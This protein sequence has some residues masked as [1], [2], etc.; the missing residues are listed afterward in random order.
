MATRGR[1]PK[2]QAKTDSLLA[3]L[4][5]IA[6]AQ[7]NEGTILQRHCVLH[8]GWLAATDNVMTLACKVTDD[9]TA[10]P[11][12][13]RLIA[14]L[15]RC[16]AGVT[17]TQEN[18]DRLRVVSAGLRVSVPCVE[19]SSMALSWADPVGGPLTPAFIDGLRAIGHITSETGQDLATGSILCEGGMLKAVNNR[20]VLVEYWHGEDSP[21]YWVL[22]A[23]TV[24]ALIKIDKK[25]VGLG[26]S[27]N[28]ATFHYEDESWLK[29]QLYNDKWPQTE[30]VWKDSDLT[31]SV[32]VPET[33][34]AAVNTL[35]GL[36]DA[37]FVMMQEG[38]LVTT[39]KLTDASEMDVIGLPAGPTLKIKNLLMVAKLAKTMHIV[40]DS[41][42][43]IYFY[44]DKTRMAISIA[45]GAEQ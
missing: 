15:E 8:S 20:Q 7:S 41:S 18:A 24:D 23:A 5:F 42:R 10:C 29:T 13:K 4:R 35:S 6:L 2:S 32:P 38:K 45:V 40:S 43:V 25:L 21:P 3:A 44:G 27:G 30:N 31:G 34:F 12:T 26:F 36:T 37:G 22:P 17:I 11:Q 16:G 19:L 1:K 33:F 39:N 9:L 28:S 14:A